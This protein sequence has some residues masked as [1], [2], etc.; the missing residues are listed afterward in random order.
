MTEADWAKAVLGFCTVGT[1]V[2]FTIA[3][4]LNRLHLFNPEWPPHARFHNAMQ[5]TSLYL[6]SLFSLAALLGPL[7]WPKAL[8]AAL[9]SITF[10]PGLFAALPIPG[11]SVWASKALEERGVPWNLII[12]ALFLIITGLGLW[13]AWRAM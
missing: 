12:A 5:G 11:T 4:L 13:L 10:W 7:T 3:D 1:C 6:V 8:A 2:A 9:A